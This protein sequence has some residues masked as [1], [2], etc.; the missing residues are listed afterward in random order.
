MRAVFNFKM[1]KL[2]EFE[3][4]DLGHSARAEAGCPSTDEAKTYEVTW[5][6]RRNQ[7]ETSWEQTRVQKAPASTHSLTLAVTA[8]AWYQSETQLQC[9]ISF[10]MFSH[11]F[12][13]LNQFRSPP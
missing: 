8:E 2:K 6:I 3:D 13:G 10:V 5:C 12:M 7:L 11:F 9:A 4:R 1:S